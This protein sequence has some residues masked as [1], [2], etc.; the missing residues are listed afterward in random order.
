M[1][2]V[3]ILSPGSLE[4]ALA[5]LA[6]R[7]PGLRVLA[8]GTDMIVQVMEK[9]EHPA[10]LLSIGQLPG[11]SYIRE[12]G[13][14]IRIGA[15]TLHADIERSPLLGEAAPAL[16]EAVRL[17]GSPPLRSICTIGG[18]IVNASP[19]AD[20]VPPLMTLDATLTLRSA[21]GAR[22]A[23]V[24]E[25]FSAP[26]KCGIEP[27]E[28]L[29]GISFRRP[30]P[31]HVGFYER[32]GQRKLLSISKVGVALAAVLDGKRLSEVS[33]ALG[34]VA[35]TV[36]MAPR[37]AAF[38]EGRECTEAVAREAARIAESESRAITD[39]RSTAPYRNRMAGALLLRG[40]ERVVGI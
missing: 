29:V 4:E 23:R 13:G 5:I 27:D 2:D 15:L 10:S 37:A 6:E 31:G 38:L 26:G 25:F 12:D 19:V 11:L 24:R 22:E 16:V 39:I 21:S 33:I 30:P 1:N 40:L 28:L 14:V 8:G 7:R 34:A 20:S 32:L 3:E 18:N 17:I 35:P 36:I 9:K